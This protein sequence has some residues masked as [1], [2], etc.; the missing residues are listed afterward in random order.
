MVKIAFCFH[1]LVGTTKVEKSWNHPGGELDVLTKSYLSLKKHILDHNDVDIFGHTWD[2][3]FNTTINSIYNPKELMVETQK[4]FDVPNHIPNTD[5]VQAHYSRWYSTKQSFELMKKYTIKNKIKYDVVV[6]TRW[7]ILFL[8]NIL[9][10]NYNTQ[11]FFNGLT[12]LNNWG[13][14]NHPKILDLFFFSN[15]D[16]M[17]QFVALYDNLNDYTIHCPHP[18]GEHISSHHLALWHLKKT[19]L[20]TKF[21]TPIVLYDFW[22]APPLDQCD[23]SLIRYMEN[24]HGR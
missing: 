22:N 15:L 5:R 21:K 14:P 20:I 6:S 1:G 18:N 2:V 16:Y 10:I 17:S 3:K 12:R 8:R 9:F 23:I 13:Y 7:D 19:G 24:E 11:N 4:I